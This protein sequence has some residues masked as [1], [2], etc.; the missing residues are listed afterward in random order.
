[1]LGTVYYNVYYSNY[2]IQ[3]KYGNHWGESRPNI[4]SEENDQ[5]LGDLDVKTF[6]FQPQETLEKILVIS[7]DHIF[8][9]RL[10]TNTHTYGDLSSHKSIVKSFTLPEYHSGLYY[11]SVAYF[12]GA[13]GTARM[14]SKPFL[15]VSG[16][17]VHHHY[18]NCQGKDTKY[19]I[20]CLLK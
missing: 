10:I 15:Y 18:D 4:Y 17:K 5:I 14:N 12:T 20:C 13:A 7:E 16:L 6:E 2:S 9:M 19:S 1:M 11:Q 3:I 8:G